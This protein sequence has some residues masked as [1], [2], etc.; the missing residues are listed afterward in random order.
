MH[1]LLTDPL[2]GVLIDDEPRSASLPEVLALLSEGRIDGYTG[3]RAHQSDSWHVFLVQLAAAI[4]ARHP[5][6]TLPVDVSYWRDGLLELAEGQAS[7]WHL[8]EEDVTKPAFL[9]H[10]WSS[11]KDEAEAYGVKFDDQ[12]RVKSIKIKAHTPD[13]LDVVLTSRNHDVK[14][15]RVSDA[16][17]EAWLFALL[18]HQ[19]TNGYLGKG[20]GVVRMYTGTGNRPIVSWTSDRH[21]ARRFQEEA[22]LVR[23]MRKDLLMR[24]G[25]RDDGHVLTWVK[26]WGR[27]EHQYEDALQGLDPC[28]IE[29]CRTVRLRPNTAGGVVA[30]NAPR[31]GRQIGPKSMEEGDVGDP[32]IPLNLQKEKPV[33]LNVSKSGFTPKLVTNL[34]FEQGFELTALQKARAGG[35]AGWLIASALARGQGKTEG[36]HRLELP[37]PAKVKAALFSREGASARERG[38]K[39]AQDLLADAKN[40]AGALRTA[41]FIL[42]EG[43]PGQ[44]DFQ[45]KA[46]KSWVDASASAFE[47]S[48]PQHYY[49]ALWR[50][51][52]E[53][54]ETVFSNW[55]RELVAITR[56]LL[57]TAVQRLPTPGSRRW[58]ALTRS[59]AELTRALRKH[60]LLPEA[61]PDLEKTA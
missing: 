2:I 49:P 7:A 28:F 8:L 5:T 4:L 1:D 38:A 6:D 47:Q 11:W 37:V 3:L 58:R 55:R 32:W 27:S 14:A 12:G 51:F 45:K 21:P 30:L 43:G 36:F 16:D 9:Q 53:P 44:A 41:L 17:V 22:M 40:A 31:K 20:Y 60:H 48:W 61:A 34:L 19:T 13:Q 57:D 26:P 46:I 18:M 39:C 56:E 23:D 25:Y 42:A 35:T 33:A 10:P 59:H 24:Y 15:C 52:D 54:T 50:A 29:A